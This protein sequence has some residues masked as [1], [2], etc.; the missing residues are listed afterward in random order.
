MHTA[1]SSGAPT[2]NQNSVFEDRLRGLHVCNDSF[3]CEPS[4][5]I[6]AS[7]RTNGWPS[8]STVAVRAFIGKL[9]LRSTDLNVTADMIDFQIARSGSVVGIHDLPSISK[10]H[11]SFHA[12]P[13]S[14]ADRGASS[15]TLA[16][17]CS[18]MDL[19]ST[20]LATSVRSECPRPVY[21]PSLSLRMAMLEGLKGVS[22]RVAVHWAIADKLG[23]GIELG[24]S[25][26]TVSEG[27]RTKTELEEWTWRTWYVWVSVQSTAFADCGRISLLDVADFRQR[28]SDMSARLPKKKFSRCTLV[29]GLRLLIQEELG[30]ARGT[31]DFADCCRP[32]RV[33]HFH[34]GSTLP[35]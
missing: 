18:P 16:L 35:M 21:E 10:A 33:C 8:S 28:L 1:S 30:E 19:A 23:V 7:R 29:G 31:E 4:R 32:Q 5:A 17:L 27:W 11:S 12:V 22:S 14:P 2:R 20:L 26:S 3:S 15:R 6:T 25:L 13:N 9:V 34:F 24:L